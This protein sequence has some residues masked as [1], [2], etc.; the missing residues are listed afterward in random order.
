MF[1]NDSQ[2]KLE[3]G[4]FSETPLITLQINSLKSYWLLL[5]L[6]FSEC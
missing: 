6:W 1:L 4:G 3:Q 2:E 5:L